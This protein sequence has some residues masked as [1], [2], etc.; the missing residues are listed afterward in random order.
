MPISGSPSPDPLPAD[1]GLA[2][3]GILSGEGYLAHRLDPPYR[4]LDHLIFRDLLK[5]IR[6]FA[7]E[8]EGDLL[9]YGS[10]GSPYRN[11]FPKVTRYVAADILPGP[12]VTLAL[13]A[14]GSVP[15][16]DGTF[17][18]VLSTQVLE[19]VPDPHR[20]LREAWR[21]LRPGGR[22][23]V[24][25]HGL[26]IEHGCPFDF[27]RWTAVGLAAAA[28]NAGFEVLRSSK[29]VGGPRGS[30]HLLHY[31]V[32]ELH[33]PERPLLHCALAVV[34]NLYRWVGLPVL[35]WVGGWFEN[36]SELPEDHR[37][38]VFT[39]VLV[40]LRKPTTSQA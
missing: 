10:G 13:G 3:S 16:P 24:T 21:V 22:M 37:T 7:S 6:R 11:L 28:R 32:A 25:T 23:L 2:L 9:D 18:S 39:G 27:H 15:L 8:C 40:E 38:P 34:R 12:R 20:Y 31:A 33:Q 30:I 26:Y 36:M 1:G 4:D 35:N 14:D 5:V 17:D 19:H 29:L